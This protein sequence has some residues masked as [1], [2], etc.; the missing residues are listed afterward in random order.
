[1]LLLLLLILLLILFLIIIFLLL[2]LFWF[3]GS[4]V[5]VRD[6]DTDNANLLPSQ[7]AVCVTYRTD[8]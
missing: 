8:N 5:A 7:S 1:M 3:D 2:I 6:G 4:F